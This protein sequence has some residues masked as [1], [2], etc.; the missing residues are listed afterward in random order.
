MSH[1]EALADCLTLDTTNAIPIH[2]H[3]PHSLAQFRDTAPDHI[4]AWLEAHSEFTAEPDTCLTIPS[5]S[6]CI[7]SVIAGV[8]KDSLNLWSLAALPSK[9]PTAKYTIGDKLDESLLQELALGWELSQYQFT[10]EKHSPE[11]EKRTLALPGGMAIE[12]V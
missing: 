5:E 1:N 7:G 11:S 4:K 3:D 12:T 8:E 6:G 9:L 10:I 2:L